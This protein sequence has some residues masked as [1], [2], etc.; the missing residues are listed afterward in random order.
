MKEH[1]Q[2]GFTLPELLVVAGVFCVLAVGSILLLRQADY[3]MPGRNGNRWADVAQLTV[4][5]TK[6]ASANGGLPAGLPASATEI[7]SDSNEVDLCKYLVPTYLKELPSDP[8]SGLNLS[9]GDCNT[10]K[11]LYTSGYTIVLKNNLVTIAAPHAEGGAH[12]SLSHKF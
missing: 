3:A 12:I 1:G 2:R 6:Y 4:A 9:V 7:G 8:T 11:A 10:G 5:L